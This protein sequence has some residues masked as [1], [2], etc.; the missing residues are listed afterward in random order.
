MKLNK[1]WAGLTIVGIPV[2]IWFCNGTLQWL[3]GY[4]QRIGG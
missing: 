2:T 1:I 4:I 3:I